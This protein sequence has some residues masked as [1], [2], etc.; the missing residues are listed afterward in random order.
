MNPNI[1]LVVD[2]DSTFVKLETLEEISNEALKTNSRKNEIQE[3]I[4][5]ITGK[6]MRGEISFSD[7]LRRRL[8]LFS[9]DQ[10]DLEKVSI[11]LKKEVSDSFVENKDFFKKNGQRIY[12]VSGGFRECIFPV[13]DEFG[14]PRENVLANDFVFNDKGEIIGIDESNLSSKTLGK[15]RQ[16]E[17]LGLKG[18]IIMLGDG[19][20]DFEVKKEHQADLFLAYT[21]NV[22]RNSVV[23]LADK[24]MKNLNEVIEFIK[25]R[26]GKQTN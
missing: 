14:I 25:K 12:V 16:L 17:N 4:K 7:S 8:K 9:A 23:E 24:E 11:R 20:T 18:E 2:F 15:V 21:E 3:E 19:W 1:F 5:K 22:R 6:G 10:N 26:N 13:T